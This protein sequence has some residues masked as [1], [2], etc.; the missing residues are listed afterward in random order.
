[1]AEETTGVKP[2]ASSPDAS[3]GVKQSPES[4][5]GGKKTE[6][7]IPYERFK[8]LQEENKILSELLGQ[9]AGAT[10]EPKGAGN[11]A[12]GTDNQSQVKAWMDY[13]ATQSK[14]EAQAAIAGLRDQFELKEVLSKNKDFAV[15][16]DFIKDYRSVHPNVSFEDAYLIAKAKSGGFT[17][18]QTTP[19]ES[20]PPVG[21]GGPSKTDTPTF[22]PE[23]AIMARTPDGKFKYTLDEVQAMFGNK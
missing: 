21:T 11:E 13:I 19:V 5:E 10:P 23:E 15:F 20:A 6:E 12:F 17:A 18:Q 16:K 1:M 22:S 2:D 14:Q 7:A 3:A 9:T 4:P 8:Q